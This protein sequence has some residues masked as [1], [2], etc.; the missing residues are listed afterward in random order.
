LVWL[1]LI[2]VGAV[3]L[4]SRRGANVVRE[5]TA[6]DHVAHRGELAAWDRFCRDHCGIDQ[7]DGMTGIEFE[8]RLGSLFADLGYDAR[9]TRTSGDF[10]ADLILTG[11]DGRTLVQAKR[12]NGA[13]GVKGVQEAFSAISY[14]EADRAILVTNGR[15]TRAAE[16]LAERT[17]VELWDRGRLIDSLTETSVDLP[18]P[19]DEP[20]IRYQVPADR[21]ERWW[22]YLRTGLQRY[23]STHVGWTSTLAAA[24]VGSASA[25]QSRPSARKL[26][27]AP[28]KARRYCDNCGRQ[29]RGR[30]RRWCSQRCAK[31]A[32]RNRWF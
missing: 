4:V 32:R 25:R 7:V 2:V 15:F 8:D 26:A 23:P 9:K 12:S 14:Y 1:V 16:E 18:D 22:F 13:V 6:F 5:W 3:V 31:Q 27:R 28:V 19:P 17:K 10:G 21:G 30:R 24:S 29:L 11:D 20:M